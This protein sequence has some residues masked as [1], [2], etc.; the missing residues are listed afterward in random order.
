MGGGLSLLVRAVRFDPFAHEQREID[1]YKLM[2]D[3]MK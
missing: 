1:F 2:I 3:F